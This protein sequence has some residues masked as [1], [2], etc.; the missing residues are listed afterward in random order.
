MDD[1]FSEIPNAIDIRYGLPR[2]DWQAVWDWVEA[3]V[4]PD[5]LN[6]A[7]TRFAED[8]LNRLINALPVDY[9]VY[10]SAE[11]LLLTQRDPSLAERIL[12]WCEHARRTIL[13][14][15]ASIAE[16][17]GYGKHVVL[18]FNTADSYYDYIADFYPDDGEFADSAGVFLNEGYGHFALFLADGFEYGRSIAHELTHALL[19]HLPLPLWVNEGV[20]QITEDVVVGETSFLVDHEL[21][22]RHRAYWNQETIHLFWSGDSFHS[23]DEGQELSYSLARILV[24]NLMSDFPNGVSAFINAADYMDAGN[25]ALV[26]ACGVSLAKRVEQFIGDGPW[27]PRSDYGDCDDQ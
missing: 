13:R 14:T 21:V 12:Q 15:L 18:A 4:E 1:S 7:W 17:E 11:F 16:D 9:E 19:R 3:N 23:P 2:P 27:T 10:Q 5:K 22:Q 6:D 20:T 24:R 8:W 25:S 26:S